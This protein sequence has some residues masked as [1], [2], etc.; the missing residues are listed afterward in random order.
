[1][2]TRPLPEKYD[3]ELNPIAI[4]GKRLYLYTIGNWDIFVNR[5]AQEGEE[6]IKHFPF[7]IK[8]WEA[9]IVL[10]DHLIRIGLAPETEILEIGAGMGVTGLFLAAFGH[11]VTITDHEE[12]ALELVR[13]NV[14]H[15]KLDHVSVRRLDWNAPDLT[16]TYDVICGSELVYNETC[17]RP[18]IDLFRRYLRP[19]ATVFLAHDLRRSCILKFIGM[20]PGRFE[21]DNVV[22]T[23]RGQHELH[24]VVIHSLRLKP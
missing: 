9:S 2:E 10:A 5:L 11:K 16:G 8:I 15:N 4:G 6:Y 3:L 13:M 7:W 21:I 14:E 17:I 18:I 24:Q 20:V 23:M 22:K 12:D 1:M 19:E